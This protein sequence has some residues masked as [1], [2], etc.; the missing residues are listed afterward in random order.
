MLAVPGYMLLDDKLHLYTKIKNFCGEGAAL[1]YLFGH[2]GLISA[3]ALTAS[4]IE[5]RMNKRQAIKNTQS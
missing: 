2:P 3:L 4:T 5:A 1:A